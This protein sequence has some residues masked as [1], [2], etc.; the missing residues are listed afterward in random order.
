MINSSNDRASRT[1][2]RSIS[3]LITS[4]KAEVT[5]VV[6]REIAIAKKEITDIVVKAGITAALAAVLVFFL[7][8]AWVMLLFTA[9][10]GLVAL[11]LSPWLSFLIVAAALIVLGLILGLAAFLVAKRIKGPTTT[12]ETAT[13]AVGAVQGKRPVNAADYDDAYEELYGKQV[14]A[15]SVEKTKARA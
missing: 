12:V 13:S 3:E 5:G 1:S 10:W 7:L 14:A 4:I 15:R 6:Q 9:A 11:G 8:S 2:Q